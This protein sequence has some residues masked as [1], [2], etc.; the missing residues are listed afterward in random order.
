MATLSCGKRAKSHLEIRSVV[1]DCEEWCL[2]NAHYKVVK[3]LN[4]EMKMVRAML[5]MRCVTFERM[6]VRWTPR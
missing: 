6:D 2:R 3:A 5:K 1:S 4:E